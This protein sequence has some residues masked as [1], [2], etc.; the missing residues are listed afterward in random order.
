MRQKNKYYLILPP[1]WTAALLWQRGLRNSMKLWAVL[2]KTTQDRMVIVKSS[3]KMWSPGEKNGNPTS[4]L[5]ARTPWKAWKGK[6][7]RHWK[8]S[9]LGWKVSNMLLRKNKWQLLI[10][11]KNEADGLKQKWQRH[12]FADKG[13][14]SQKYSHVQMWQ[15]DYQEGWAPKNWGFRIL[16]LE[17]TL[18]SPFDCKEIKLVNPKGNQL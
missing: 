4:I 7:I 9:P 17:K 6:K 15:L 3:D 1:S 16:V 12:H 2:C 18:E 14:Y 10:A 11:P 8:M 13:P 5:A